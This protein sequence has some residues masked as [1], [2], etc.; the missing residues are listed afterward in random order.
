MDIGKQRVTDRWVLMRVMH[1]L[2][3]NGACRR[4][5]SGVEMLLSESID[6]ACASWTLLEQCVSIGR[7]FTFDDPIE[8]DPFI[9]PEARAVNEM[10]ENAALYSPRIPSGVVNE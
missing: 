8:F 7:I 10:D 1:R 9:V 5:S 2:A 3:G 4:R 6:L